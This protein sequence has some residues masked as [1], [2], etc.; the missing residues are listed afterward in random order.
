M[1]ELLHGA[2]VAVE[3]VAALVDESRAQ[4]SAINIAGKF[5]ELLRKW[6]RKV[7]KHFIPPPD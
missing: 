4:S 6:L 3:A 7:T 5:M 2:R 1:K